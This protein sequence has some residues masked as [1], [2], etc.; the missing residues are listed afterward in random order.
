VTA[1][2]GGAPLHTPDL[3]FPNVVAGSESYHYCDID[4]SGETLSFAAVSASGDTLDEFSLNR[5]VT[6]VDEERGHPSQRSFELCDASPNPFNPTTL[7]RF[8]VPDGGGY[9]TLRIYD[10][11]GKLVRIL[12]D[13]DQTAGDKRVTW[14][15]RNDD[16]RLVATGVYFYRMTA[17][18]FEQT[19]KIV[20]LR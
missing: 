17:P 5:T 15:G 9:V 7:I 12:V 11:A 19:K 13:G 16:G 2:G 8:S 1:G 4:I 14:S 3:G 20:L 6:A 10:V 18:G